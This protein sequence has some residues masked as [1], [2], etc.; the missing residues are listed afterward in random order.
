MGTQARLWRGWGDHPLKASDKERTTHE[1]VKTSLKS[2]HRV[3]KGKGYW[4]GKV[5]TWLDRHPEPSLGI[6][7]EP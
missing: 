3:R 6:T 7:R 5:P 4:Q 2:G 1:T